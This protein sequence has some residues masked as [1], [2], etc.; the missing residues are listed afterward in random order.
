MARGN[1][2]MLPAAVGVRRVSWASAR[3]H[4]VDALVP[5]LFIAP[6]LISF[7]VFFL[8]PSVYS[9]NL[10]FFRYQ[11][12]GTPSYVGLHNYEALIQYPTFW[13]SVRNTLIYLLGQ[14]LPVMVGAFLLAVAVQST[15]VPLKWKRFY[16]PMIFLP[17]VMAPVAAALVWQV[18]F[19]TRSGVLNQLLGRPVPW[20][21]DPVL[22]KL[23]V[24]VTLLWRATG[25]YFVVFLAGLTS[26]SNDIHEAA[27][28]D[29]AGGVQR[30][31]Y[32][33]IPLLRPI[34]L[35][36]FVINTIASLRIYA[37]PNLLFP[38]HMA[39]AQAQPIMNLVVGNI[40][41]GAFGMAAAVG[42][43]LFVLILAVSA[44]QFRLF[45]RGAEA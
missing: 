10:S 21:A 28:I 36:A 45:R 27:T 19:S 20:L 23:S 35:F 9:L 40:Q 5:Y 3:R 11:G 31:V 1:T 41:N 18:I 16:K 42:W 8:G 17:Q 13:M 4:A 37:E 33:T 24:I 43:L 29:G 25:W 39:P 44:V 6:F 14:T 32:V 22:M 34:F 38:M 26:I 30:L 2:V 15:L 7:V 12:F